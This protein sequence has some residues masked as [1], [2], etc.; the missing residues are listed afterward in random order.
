MVTSD[1][2]DRLQE[3]ISDKTIDV[4]T[5]EERLKRM[6]EQYSEEKE[7]FVQEGKVFNVEME[8]LEAKIRKTT[9]ENSNSLLLSEQNLQKTKIE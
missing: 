4:S 5:V 7:K 8:S 2:F 9:M 1:S 3:A 6:Q